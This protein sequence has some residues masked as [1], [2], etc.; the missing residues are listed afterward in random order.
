MFKFLSHIIFLFFSNLVA[1]LIANY[2]IPGFSISLDFKNLSIIAGIF[3][4]L[5]IF[6][7][8]IIKFVLSPIIFLTFGLGIILVN[9]IIL[10]IV[11]FYSKDV[12][13]SSIKA[14]FFATLVIS[15]VNTII[16]FSARLLFKKQIS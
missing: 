12:S 1:F 8:P 5:N 2:F 9:A 4:L 14:L 3:T 13:I 16:N 6:I 7:K 15:F 11:N 10:Q